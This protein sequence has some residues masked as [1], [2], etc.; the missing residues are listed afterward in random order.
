MF[1]NFQYIHTFMNL[2]IIQHLRKNE[3][4]LNK[5]NGQIIEWLFFY[6]I[7]IFLCYIINIFKNL[8]YL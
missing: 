2:K 6:I 3:K 8:F 1:F 7:F 4:T 5:T